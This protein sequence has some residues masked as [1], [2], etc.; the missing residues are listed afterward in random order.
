MKFENKVALVTGAYQ[1]LG[2][3]ISKKLGEQGCKLIL[4]D[5]DE[6]VKETEKEFSN[7]GMDSI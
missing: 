4:V 3:G 7:L 5:I 1:G 2:K 6:R